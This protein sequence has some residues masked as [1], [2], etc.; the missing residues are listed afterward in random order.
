MSKLVAGLIFLLGTT[1]AQA[2]APLDDIRGPVNQAIECMIKH[3]RY[4]CLE[5]VKVVAWQC[6]TKRDTGQCLTAFDTEIKKHFP[7]PKQ[8]SVL[9]PEASA[10]LGRMREDAVA[11]A[12]AHMDHVMEEIERRN[13]RAAEESVRDRDRANDEFRMREMDARIDRIENAERARQ[14]GIG[15]DY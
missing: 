14:F 7:D 4:A 12:A 1:A 15:R 3:G 5:R 13:E 6:G 9:T 2:G 8:K 11:R 10:I